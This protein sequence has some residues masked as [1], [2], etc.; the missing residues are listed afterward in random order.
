MEAIEVAG[1]AL[2]GE[3][4]VEFLIEA[5]KLAQARGE[6]DRAED[7][8]MRAVSNAP[9]SRIA[10]DA[11]LRFAEESRRFRLAVTALGLGLHQ[12]S[13]PKDQALLYIWRADLA[14]FELDDAALA[15]SDYAAALALA[16]DGVYAE[17]LQAISSDALPEAP[18][19]SEADRQYERF[20]LGGAA[21][22]ASVELA[23]ALDRE[24]ALEEALEVWLGVLREQETHAREAMRAIARIGRQVGRADAWCRG[25]AAAALKP[26]TPPRRQRALIQELVRAL[27]LMT[28]H[29]SA[30]V[31]QGAF[32][33]LAE[34]DEA[35]DPSQSD[36]GTGFSAD[37]QSAEEQKP[38]S[39]EV[40]AAMPDPEPA[41]ASQP[42]SE[43]EASP[44]ASSESKRE[45]SPEAE[46]EADLAA[47]LAPEPE[48]PLQVAAEHLEAGFAPLPKLPEASASNAA[49]TDFARISLKARLLK[50]AEGL[51]EAGSFGGWMALGRQA[52]SAAQTELAEEAYAAAIDAADDPS[53]AAFAARSA[54]QLSR[55]AG[56]SRRALRYAEA[57]VTH[58]ASSQAYRELA[59]LASLAGD[60]DRSQ[61]AW[62]AVLEKEPG[63]LLASA[64]L[65]RRYA[66]D[67]AREEALRVMEGVK[68]GDQPPKDQ[69]RWL[70]DLAEAYLQLDQLTGAH[71]A[72]QS[73]LGVEPLD[74]TP[75]YQMVLLGV[76]ANNS[77]WVDQGLAELAERSIAAGARERSFLAAASLVARD[78]ASDALKAHYFALKGRRQGRARHVLPSGWIQR[79]VSM[80]QESQN[81]APPPP[82]SKLKSES[83]SRMVR[84]LAERFG[85]VA[86][87]VFISDSGVAVAE[88]SAGE[89]PRIWVNPKSSSLRFDMGRA[90]VA[91]MLPSLQSGLDPV[92]G[93]PDARTALDRAAA[94]ALDDPRLA[95]EAVGPHGSRGMRLLA[96]LT[97]QDCVQLSEVAGLGLLSI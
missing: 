94:M 23:E 15:Q 68:L 51:R 90:L 31:L 83:L 84:D 14:A 48:A 19:L 39:S 93:D 77:A 86:P 52:L 78:R 18:L 46:A 63:D 58:E 44:E 97:S 26:K 54:S 5:A 87:E 32:Q 55:S 16:P 67:G 60:V 85:T 61:E 36:P 66:E 27:T 6:V 89:G 22:E 81:R 57:L 29:V 2:G 42:E 17:R 53:E 91:L 79:W 28:D 71:D 47:M 56:Q 37:L 21:M 80:P 40:E 76:R 65:V 9:M 50:R 33:L 92:T 11:L 73:A 24:G 12:T 4:S 70:L 10:V 49:A 96:F 3:L 64:V 35:L 62:Q 72:L 25:L 20:G 41:S 30:E 34:N 95:L 7:L 59:E 74:P 69:C 75:A 43:P 82:A 45:A 38:D 8:L 1:N 13:R 88:A